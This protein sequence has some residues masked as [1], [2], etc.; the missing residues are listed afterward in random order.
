MIAESE[1][2]EYL[3]EMR[4]HVC[5]RCVERPEGGPPCAPLGKNC[6][7]EMHLPRLVESIRSIHSDLVEP[8]LEHNRRDICAH[9]AFLHSDIC[10]CPMDYLSVLVVEAVEAVDER[11]RE[12][13]EAR[14]AAVGEGA[15]GPE[16]IRAAYQRATGRW[17]GCDWSTTFGEMGLD[18]NGWSA[19]SAASMAKETIDE[20][21]RADWSAAAGWLGQIERAAREAETH[22][23]A[24]VDA[25]AAGDWRR[26]REQAERAWALEFSTGRP[27][28]HSYP[29]AWQDMHRL[30]E[31]ACAAR[32]QPGEGRSR[33]TLFCRAACSGH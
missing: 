8:Y 17:R 28:W 19:A 22:A 30:V 25:V 23:A 16:E 5:A 2:Q 11:R 21:L 13:N 3:D 4:R 10:P 27:I 14:P 12:R 24:A 29:F 20:Q 15:V 1:L 6:G 33:P 26:A 32:L 7:L 18:L 31:T 9:C